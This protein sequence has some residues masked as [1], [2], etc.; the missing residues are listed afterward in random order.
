MTSA[1]TTLD[2]A[3]DKMVE[4]AK[5][6]NTLYIYQGLI[7]AAYVNGWTIDVVVDVTKTAPTTYTLSVDG[8]NTDGYVYAADGTTKLA[9]V[10]KE[11]GT[12]FATSVEEA[13]TAKIYVTGVEDTLGN[14]RVVSKISYTTG[15]ETKKT[16]LATGTG[17]T[18]SGSLSMSSIKGNVKFYV[19]TEELVVLEGSTSTNFDL[20]DEKGVKVVSGTTR[21]VSGETFTFY[22]QAKNGK[23][24]DK[25]KYKIGGETEND[26]LKPDAKGKYTTVAINDGLSIEITD[27]T[28]GKYDVSAISTAGIQVRD[29]DDTLLNPSHIESVYYGPA[30]GFETYFGKTYPGYG[31]LPSGLPKTGNDKVFAVTSVFGG[32]VSAIDPATTYIG[33]I[34]DSNVNGDNN[35]KVNPNVGTGSSTRKGTV[36]MPVLYAGTGYNQDLSALANDDTWVI[37]ATTSDGTTPSAVGTISNLTLVSGT[38]TYDF[39]DWVTPNK[40]ING[41][42]YYFVVKPSGATKLITNVTYTIGGTEYDAEFVSG[43]PSDSAGGAIYR[44]VPVTGD[45]DIFAEEMEYVTLTLASGC[46][47]DVT[48]KDGTEVTT[49]G[50]KIE[51]NKPVDIIV[52]AKD[53]V[54]PYTVTKVA[55]GATELGKVAGSYTI[56]SSATG[57][58]VTVTVETEQEAD[59]SKYSVEFKNG[60]ANAKD[61]PATD[62]LQST[63]NASGDITA[64]AL[65]LKV[66][67]TATLNEASF[68]TTIKFTDDTTKD[69]SDAG[70]TVKYSLGKTTTATKVATLTNETANVKVTGYKVGTDDVTATFKQTDPNYANNKIVY[71]GVLP[72]T[73]VDPFTELYLDSTSDAIMVGDTTTGA[74]LSVKYK[75]GRTGDA[76]TLAA[77]TLGTGNVV[78]SFDPDLSSSS[79]FTY[80]YTD[81]QTPTVT[82]TGASAEAKVMAL[83]TATAGTKITATATIYKDGSTTDVLATLQKE[84]TIVPKASYKVVPSVSVANGLTYESYTKSEWTSDAT[85][86]STASIKTDDQTKAISLDKSGNK[87]SAVVKVDIYELLNSTNEASITNKAELD[88]AVKAGNAKLVS[89]GKTFTTDV[90]YNKSN[91][92]AWSKAEVTRK[93]EY[94][95]LAGTDGNFTVSAAKKTDVTNPSN[96]FG[97][98]IVKITP[99]VNGVALDPVL[100]GFSVTEKAADKT[101]TF[102]LYGK[103]YSDEGTFEDKDG[104]AT[105]TPANAVIVENMLKT[106]YLS[107]S[108]RSIYKDV[109]WKYNAGVKYTVEQTNVI[110]LPTEEDFDATTRDKRAILVGW[111]IDNVNNAATDKGVAL[112]AGNIGLAPGAKVSILND[113]KFTAVWAPRI[114]LSNDSNLTFANKSQQ[115]TANASFQNGIVKSEVTNDEASAI[116][117]STVTMDGYDVPLGNI[118]QNKTIPVAIK[119]YRAWGIN[120]NGTIKQQP[121]YFVTSLDLTYSTDSAN[122]D[123]ISLSGTNMTGDAIQSGVTKIVATITDPSDSS[124]SWKVTHPSIDVVAGNTYKVAFTKGDETLNTAKT[125]LSDSNKLAKLSLEKSQSPKTAAVYPVSFVSGTD[126]KMD[127]ASCKVVYSIDKNG[128]IEYTANSTDKWKLDVTPEAVG[129]ATLTVNITDA[130]G[131]ETTGTL[132]IEVVE[133][134]VEIQLTNYAGTAVTE[135]EALGY[136]DNAT[137]T[138]KGEE[139]T[140]KVYVKAILKSDSSD[141]TGNLTQWSVAPIAKQE[142]VTSG[143]TA[144]TSDGSGRKMIAFSTASSTV[145]GTDSDNVFVAFT[146]TDTAGNVTTY[147]KPI[148][149]TTYYNLVLS[150]L[151]TY[152]ETNYTTGGSSYLF[153]KVNGTRQLDAEETADKGKDVPATTAKIKITAA[154]QTVKRNTDGKIDTLAE[155]FNVFNIDLAKYSAEIVKDEKVLTTGEFKFW[156]VDNGAGAGTANDFICNGDEIAYKKGKIENLAQADFVNGVYTLA[157]SMGATAISSI[158]AT[159]ATITL[160]DEKDQNYKNVVLALTPSKTA[161]GLV[162]TADNWGFFNWYADKKDSYTT[163]T[164]S[165]PASAGAA[166]AGLAL[167]KGAGNGIAPDNTL[168]AGTG[169]FCVGMVLG[170]AGKT[171]LKVYSELDTLLEK[172]LA[173]IEL[174]IDGLNTVSATEVYYVENGT[175]IKSDSRTIGDYTYVFGDDGKQIQGTKLYKLANG[176]TILIR[177]GAAAKAG[178][179][180]MDGDSYITSSTGEVLSGWQD[181]EGGRYYADPDNNNILVD[182]LQTISGKAYYFVSHALAKAPATANLYANVTGTKYY[183]N[184]AGEVAT[185]DICKVDGKDRL[186][187]ADSTIVKHDDAD[188]VEGKILVGDTI[189]VIKDDDTAEPDHKHA[190][191]EPVW[192]WTPKDTGVP[193]AAVATFTCSVGKETKDVDAVITSE[194]SGEYTDYTA[195]VT[196]EEKEYTDVITLDAEG[197]R[198]AKHTHDWKTDKK[199]T[200]DPATGVPTT[201]SL[202]FTCTVGEKPETKTVTGS[203]VAGTPNKKGAIKYTVEITGLD[204]K[205]YSTSKT[206]DASGQEISGDYNF[207]DD[208]EEDG[209]FTASF[210]GD[211]TEY[212]YTGSAIKPNVI[213]NNGEKT[214]VNGV[215]YTLKYANNTNVGTATVTVKGKGLYTSSLDLNFIITKAS[216]AEAAIGN[217]AYKTGTASDKIKPT[218]NYKGKALKFGTDFTIKSMGDLDSATNTQTLT[219]AGAGNNFDSESE[220]EVTITYVAKP[221]KI[222]ATINVAK[223]YDY[224]GEEVLTMDDLRDLVT[225]A[226]LAEGANFYVTAGD[227]VNAGTCKIAVTADGFTGTK[228]ASFKINPAKNATFTVTNADDLTTTGTKFKVTGA[229]PFVAVNAK[230]SDTIDYDLVLGKDYKVTYS[231]NKVAGTGTATINFLG[232]YKGAT[233]IVQSFKINKA[234]LDD[235]TVSAADFVK[236]KNAKSKPYMAAPDKKLFVSIDGMQIKKSEYAVTYKQGETTLTGKND[237]TFEDGVATITVEIAPSAKA[238]SL[239][240]GTTP[241][242]GEYK[243]FETA[244]GTDVSKGKVTVV[245][246]GKTA[247]VGYTGTAITFAQDDT[248]RQGDLSLKI[249][250]TVVSAKD[251]EEHFDITYVNNVNKGKAT[252]ILTAKDGDDTYTGSATGTFTIGAHVFNKAKDIK[253]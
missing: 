174:R 144:E 135:V 33:Y 122:K 31:I 145:L 214:L 49:A 36:A 34:L 126:T 163:T 48:L 249:G 252:V 125:D 71:T 216:I 159:P 107:D 100:L 27:T 193:T 208:A 185:A 175:N 211:E 231:K 209:T 50:I 195:T 210:E 108:E 52:A 92:S 160:V 10:E 120:A 146:Y 232:N 35:W 78:F 73:V 180:T 118:A 113:A 134:K 21:V 109:A 112:G 140:G 226:G 63:F 230:I 151:T 199:W 196:F 123:A 141:I 235:A 149:V 38:T 80:G 215:D 57:T 16:T 37:Q 167:K 116:A 93:T 152:H 4:Y 47:A 253:D 18:L 111:Q 41:Q 247:K 139:D 218:A 181:Y 102:E 128:I 150:G 162:V 58:N 237:I 133:D 66:G 55:Y 61:N 106:D 131:N 43:D 76:G 233:K 53:A 248:E 60:K 138:A 189:Y 46:A 2:G 39:N 246:G 45:I 176:K 110:T 206:I 213:V 173:T 188:V 178:V 23:A 234:N 148:S 85:P 182:G 88:A 64:Q 79:H 204:G 11:S 83:G 96:D 95:T 62:A 202:T 28:K 212:V 207:E 136:I 94:V 7:N 22:V 157:P 24:V 168:E 194:K 15:D 132:P 223:S 75:E 69:S 219:I 59:S 183:T 5:D 147:R 201:A 221:T 54:R 114:L 103:K 166:A 87:K 91:G 130:L 227:L 155:N 84:L 67:E 14:A 129:T 81:G 17:N 245:S 187:R 117:G 56:P 40:A 9:K 171:T 203:A 74:T 238:T 240:A 220:Q 191:G 32:D 153:T 143:S 77:G 68:Y 229:T 158:V 172:P 241:L 243:V 115:A 170:K 99:A 197:N 164:L 169:R 121:V 228:T 1:T 29:T 124:I 119:A 98:E 154:D 127:L 217:L 101:V 19:E 224:T 90:A 161:D 72:L 200:W 236:G 12:A 65:T 137:L 25:V 42:P 89:S 3:T 20:Y 6:D 205:P 225:V 222:S 104:K 97:I 251:I 30:S 190:W 242:T 184:T 198:V 70:T 177:N 165:A 44:T 156:F 51:K 105:T 239:E 8:L 250:K 179:W 82:H 186:F 192:A 142:T 244:K 86:I 13:G 26:N